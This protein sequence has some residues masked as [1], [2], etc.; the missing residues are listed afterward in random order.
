M[1]KSYELIIIVVS[2]AIIFAVYMIIKDRKK[3]PPSPG[4]AKQTLPSNVSMFSTGPQVRFAGSG[5]MAAN[6]Y[7]FSTSGPKYGATVGA[8]PAAI[9]AIQSPSQNWVG[10]FAPV[11]SAARSC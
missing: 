3:K 6:T 11:S 5:P 1:E 8:I 9:Q 4:T 7:T 10:S 2:I